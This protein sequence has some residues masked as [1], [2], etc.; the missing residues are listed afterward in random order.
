MDVASFVGFPGN[1]G[2]KWWNKKWNLPISRTV[3]IASWPRIASSNNSIPTLDVMLVSGLSFSGSSGSPIISYEKGIKAG[4]TLS[5]VSYVAPRIL[6]IMSG[7]W[8]NEEPKG[9]MFFHSGLSYFT[10][11]TSIRE[12][13]TA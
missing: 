10:R 4:A 12:L 11:A 9:G 6:G 7:H 13:L 8:W 5:T 2:K 1:D 3:H